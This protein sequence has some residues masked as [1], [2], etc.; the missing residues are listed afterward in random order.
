MVV[1]YVEMSPHNKALRVMTNNDMKMGTEKIHE[2]TCLS[3][4]RERI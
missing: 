3:D 4:I 1:T 2:G